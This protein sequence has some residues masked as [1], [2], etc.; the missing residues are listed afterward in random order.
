MCLSLLRRFLLHPLHD[1]CISNTSCCALDLSFFHRTTSLLA[2]S[3]VYVC[4]HVNHFCG[5]QP[6]DQ[7][8]DRLRL[9]LLPGRANLTAE[10]AL[11]IARE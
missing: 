2:V 11:R 5:Y 8:R 7:L 1:M 3:S 9:G 6:R 10:A 4:H